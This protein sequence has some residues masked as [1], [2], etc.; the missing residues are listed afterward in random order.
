M[1]FAVILREFITKRREGEAGFRS[2]SNTG[3]LRA[4]L[5]RRFPSAKPIL[6]FDRLGG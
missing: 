6:D 4:R 3:E 1:V 5:W 2:W